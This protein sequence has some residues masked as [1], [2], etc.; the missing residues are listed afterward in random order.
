MRVTIVKNTDQLNYEDF[1][2]GVTR[3]VT[4]A[5]VEKGRKEAQYDI[6]IE[7]DDRF[8]RPPATV[9]KQ[10]VLAYGDEAANWVGKSA[11]LY[12][13]PEVKAP[14][15]KKVGGIRV[16][17]LS[18]IDKPL[19]A[20]LTITR[21]QSG[22]FTVDPLPRADILRAQWQAAGPERRAEIEA[23]VAALQKQPEPVTA[24]DAF[25]AGGE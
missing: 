18:H 5:G 7:G 10:L 19:T 1:I 16:S 12:G 21:G 25:E 8:W 22:V 13:D 24:E 4:I 11:R 15:G 9:L 20:S 2:G 14:G 3:V 23:E 6:A 17:H